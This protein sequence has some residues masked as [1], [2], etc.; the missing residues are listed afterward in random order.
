MLL[1]TRSVPRSLRPLLSIYQQ[2]LARSLLPGAQAIAGNIVARLCLRRSAM[3][4]LKRFAL[5]IQADLPK[6]G[7]I[8]AESEASER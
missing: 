5:D 1:A 6:R 8:I 2:Q 4:T 3:W 7:N